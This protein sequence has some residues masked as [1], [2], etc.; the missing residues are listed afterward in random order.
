MANFR[1]GLAICI[2]LFLTAINGNSLAAVGK[3]EVPKPPKVGYRSFL[4]INYNKIGFGPNGVKLEN[5]YYQGGT[6][7]EVLE[8]TQE[9][10]TI[11]QEGKR[12]T[13]PRKHFNGSYGSAGTTTTVKWDLANDR[14]TGLDFEDETFWRY[15]H[16]VM[17]FI[18]QQFWKIFIFCAL[19][20]LF[21]M[22]VSE[23]YQTAIGAIFVP[24]FLWLGA[25]QGGYYQ[26]YLIE[27][28]KI[29]DA[30]KRV[31]LT[32]GPGFSMAQLDVKIELPFTYDFLSIFY[33]PAFLVMHLVA[34]YFIFQVFV[35]V[36]YLFVSHPAENVLDAVKSGKLS[37]KTGLAKIANTMYD[38]Q[39]DGIPFMWQSNNMRKRAEGLTKRLRAEDSLMQEFIK[40]L[41]TKSRFE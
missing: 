27:W 40:Y 36:N 28:D 3:V 31:K 10:I 8:Q 7:F 23:P 4:V 11:N 33:F 2:A 29:A 21:I 39:R 35:F 34:V 14:P 41:K 9:T 13:Y 38:R 37:P 1:A 26:D 22:L 20:L 30:A 19:C 32:G 6:V 18:H 5:K 12:A 24:L 16:F 15:Y 25:I 17:L